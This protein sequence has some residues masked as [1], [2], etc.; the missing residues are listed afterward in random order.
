MKTVA[1]A[2]HFNPLHI[3]HLQLINEAVKMGGIVTVIVANDKQAAL[4]RKPVLLPLEE[5]MMI[6]NHIKG[7]NQ[8]VASIDTDSTI[9]ETLKFVRPDILMSG[10]EENHPDALEE[11]EICYNLGIK[12]LWGVGGKKIRS[13]S[14]ILKKYEKNKL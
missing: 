8:V 12:T 6:L 10:C 2:G 13:S 1:I 7:V 4:K 9:K 5:R 14:E 11:A 3:G